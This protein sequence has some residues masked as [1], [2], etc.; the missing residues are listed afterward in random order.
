M[1]TCRPCGHHF[2][3]RAPDLVNEITR[4]KQEAIDEAIRNRRGRAVVRRLT[5]ELERFTAGFPAHPNVETPVP[6]QLEN[7]ND[8]DN[9]NNNNTE[10]ITGRQTVEVWTTREPRPWANVQQ[11]FTPGGC[12]MCHMLVGMADYALPDDGPQPTSLTSEWVLEKETLLPSMIKVHAYSS[13]VC[14]ADDFLTT[15]WFYCKLEGSRAGNEPQCCC[16]MSLAAC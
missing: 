5:R 15:F 8:D 10:P 12:N 7:N 16:E 1:S 4:L 11:N 2:G 9:N 14:R 6:W 3:F 13:P